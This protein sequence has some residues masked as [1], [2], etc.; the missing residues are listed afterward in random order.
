MTL[1]FTDKEFFDLVKRIRTEAVEA[2][3]TTIWA[4][5]GMTPTEAD[6]IRKDILLSSQSPYSYL[7]KHDGQI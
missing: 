3:L 6:R 5:V 2:T 1:T 4:K 7:L